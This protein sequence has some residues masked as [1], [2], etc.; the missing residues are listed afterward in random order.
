MTVQVNETEIPAGNQAT[1]LCSV[2]YPFGYGILSINW[3][4]GGI[5]VNLSSAKYDGIILDTH[6]LKI[7]DF[8]PGDSGRYRCIAA[9][10]MGTGQ[11]EEIQ[12]QMIGK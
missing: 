8:Q 2:K 12:L 1:I 5:N 6:T 3:T 9:N 7:Y 11:S 10:A 4:L